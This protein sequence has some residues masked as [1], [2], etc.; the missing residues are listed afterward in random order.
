MVD[1]VYPTESKLEIEITADDDDEI[2]ISHEIDTSGSVLRFEI[3]CSS[4]TPDMLNITG[5]GVIQEWLQNFVIDAFAHLARPKS[6]EDTLESMLGEDRAMDRAISFGTCFV[7]MHN[8]MGDN[9]VQEIKSLMLDK[10]FK[11][12]ELLRSSP[13]DKNFPKK[14]QNPEKTLS[15]LKPSEGE[16]PEDFINSEDISHRDMK[17]QGLIKIRL[18]DRTVWRGN[19]F[20]VYPNGI[21]ILTLLFENEIAAKAIFS[22]LVNEL[23][24]EDKS[25]RLKISIIKHIDK[26]YPSH[27][28]MCI[29]ENVSVSDSRTIQVASKIQTL[30]PENLDNLEKFL[31]AYRIAGCYI[32]SYAG[33]LNGKM[34]SPNPNNSKM[35]LKFDL[36][37]INAWEIGLNDFEVMAIQKDDNPLIPDGVKRPPIT[38]VLAMKNR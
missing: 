36:N 11:I 10:D 14:A 19:G 16:I 13:W 29:Y 23:G 15:E 1:R 27:Y 20:G 22:D 31:E 37:V 8:I 4:F 24:R 32:L 33:I 18:W 25:N 6:L 7:G 30:T 35:V 12:Y 34:A 26:N 28:R 3:L 2:S 21:P 5:Q 9:A 38:E 17:V